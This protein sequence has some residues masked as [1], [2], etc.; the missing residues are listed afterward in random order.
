MLDIQ[1]LPSS[2]QAKRKQKLNLKADVALFSFIP[3]SANPWL[4]LGRVGK[5]TS[6]RRVWG[7]A[8]DDITKTTGVVLS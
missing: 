3:H 1:I 6:S 5:D 8:K 2:A 4:V 7:L